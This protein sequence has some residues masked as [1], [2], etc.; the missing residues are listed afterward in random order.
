[1]YCDDAA[2]LLQAK[3]VTDTPIEPT[4]AVALPVGDDR[5]PEGNR[6]GDHNKAVSAHLLAIVYFMTETGICSRERYD[7]KYTE[8]LSCVDEWSAEERDKLLDQLKTLKS[9]LGTDET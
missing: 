5:I 1:M 4:T 6:Q 9:A 2:Q 8:A 7:A 3:Q